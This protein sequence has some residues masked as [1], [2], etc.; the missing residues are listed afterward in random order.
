M[1]QSVLTR[2]HISDVLGQLVGRYG[3]QSAYL[4]GSYARGEATPDSDVDILVVGGPSFHPADIF[5]I[6]EDAHR[7]FGK[8]IDA[9]E[10]SELNEGTPFYRSVMA[11]RVSVA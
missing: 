9:Y 10:L 4:F 6:A 8:R 2:S 5:S 7:A 11:E 3:A 1:S